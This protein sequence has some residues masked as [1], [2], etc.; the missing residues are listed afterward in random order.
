MSLS[1]FRSFNSL[2][3]LIFTFFITNACA[4]LTFTS[5]EKAR[6]DKNPT[7]TLGGDF[8]WPPYDFVGAQ[9]KHNGISADILEIISAKTGLKFDVKSGVWS[10]VLAKAKAGELDGLACAVSTEERQKYLTFTT[11]Y[12][13]MPLALIVQSSNGEIQSV[14]DLNGLTVAVNEGSYLHEWLAK[15]HPEIKLKLTKSNLES[16]E[17]ASFSQVDAYIGNVGV[18]TYLIKKH[19][20]TNLKIVAKLDNLQTKTSF[21]IQKDNPVLFNIIQ[22]ALNDISEEELNQIYKKWFF[23]STSRQI[24]L[25]K[26]EKLWIENHPVI[27]VS[28]EVDWPPFD[29]VN[30][31]GEFGGIANEYLK[32]VTELTGLKFDITTGAWSDNLQGFKNGEVELLPA[33]YKMPSRE[34]FSLFSKPYFDSINYFF[35]RSDSNIK[36]IED[37]TD[38]VLAIPKGYAHI[39]TIR[40][41]YPEV[42]LLITRSMQE[43]I[44]AVIEN[45]AQILFDNYAVLTY[46]LSH[47][48]ISNIVPFK[49]S[50]EESYQSLYFMISP[51]YPELKSIIDKVLV[52]LTLEEKNSINKLWLSSSLTTEAEKLMEQQLGING[53]QLDWLKNNREV[54][55]AGDPAWLPFE[56][57]NEDGEYVGIVSDFLKEIEKSK[58]IVFNT[59][60][61]ESWNETIQLAERGEVDVISGVEGDAVLFK[62]YLPTKSY[63]RS[64]IVIVMEQKQEFVSDLYELSDKKVVIVKDYG[65]VWKLYSNYPDQD[66]IT[67]NSVKEALEGVSIGLY[68]A[69]LLSL[70]VA[71]YQIKQNNFQNL[72]IVGK[73]NVEMFPVLFVREDLH[74]LY[75]ILNQ[76]V[77]G[78]ISK[79]AEKILDKWSKIEFA[80]QIDYDLIF[81]IVISSILILLVFIYWNLKLK[82]EIERRLII[83]ESL[84]VEKNNF[85]NLFE[86]ASDAHLI[87]IDSQIAAC[88]DSA[89]Q[90]F[91]VSAKTDM[92]F[93]RLEAWSAEQQP[94]NEAS[95]KTRLIDIYKAV[96]KG[97]TVRLDWVVSDFHGAEFWTDVIFTKIKYQG[98]NA[99]YI[100]IRDKSEQ[101]RLEQRLKQ[102]QAQLQSIIDSIPL[103]ILIATSKGHILSANKHAVNDAGNS[104]VRLKKMNIIDFFSDP[105]DMNMLLDLLQKDG[106]VK[107]Q[108]INFKAKGKLSVPMLVS[109][110]P[111]TYENKRAYLS[112]AIDMSERIELEKSLNL[113]REQ[114]ELANNA[115]SEFLANMSHEIRTPMNAILGFTELLNEQVQEPR[116]KSFVKTIQ[117]AGNTLLMLINDILDLSKIEAGKLPIQNNATNLFYLI[118]DIAEIFT[119]NIRN[120]GLELFVHVDPDLPQSIL[121]DSVR[122]RQILFNLLGNAVKFTDKGSIKLSVEATKVDQHESK[123]NL[124]ISVEDT[125]VGIAKE[126]QAK[127]FNVFEQVGEQDRNKYGGTGLGLTITK[128]LVEML[129]GTISVESQLGKGSIFKIVLNSIDIAAV[130]SVADEQKAQ[131]KTD[132]K[133]VF[134]HADILVVD[135][136]ES[137]RMLIESNFSGTNLKVTEAYDGKQAVELCEAQHFD[138]VLM[139]IQMPIM[140]GYEATELL[141]SRYPKLPVVALTASVLRNET[142]RFEKGYFDAYLRKPVMKKELFETLAEFLPH[143]VV[144]VQTATVEQSTLSDKALKH[145]YEI[146]NELDSEIESLYL[147]ANKTNSLD[148]IENFA[149]SVQKLAKQFDCEPLLSFSQRLLE[150]VESFDIAGMQAMFVEYK[151]LKHSLMQY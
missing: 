44:D 134:E 83:E 28:G 103:N 11:P 4:S 62:N 59:V 97:K 96:F 46:Q 118:D 145:I 12:T 41:K 74:E 3:V 148:D 34:V 113:A 6:I 123:L 16:L 36:Q 112:V 101:K 120:K 105:A 65:Y 111:I 25:T 26:E 109:V 21:A 133:I 13:S 99:V 55:F 140:D 53:K 1:R 75:E 19:F 18:A 42:S 31:Q 33:A 49:S 35:I 141:K 27:K 88:N 40:E 82:K 2:L 66:F 91:S 57:F 78:V 24:T 106:Y 69:A 29:F 130:S 64:P 119:I 8:F 80:R 104:V 60:Q 15:E 7:V 73:T 117:S 92:L 95:S 100:A 143:E 132:K 137:N 63:I 50:R 139:D 77:S 127:I 37:L 115:K 94:N 114:A 85:Q 107:H 79:R 110:I 61:V 108:I 47:Q 93:T 51:K 84:E 147:K 14:D 142:E 43:A 56:A 124:Q 129:G 146:Q 151:D 144:S 58:P 121:I 45:K 81:K 54:S 102:N 125:G 87:I 136:V 70:P 71:S 98:K 67:V 68:D 10:E 128:R 5:E 116:L 135:D 149:V 90:L 38:K 126:Q 39:E 122:L 48:G 52:N 72:K 17:A 150:K 30:E 131:A 20:L 138:L 76:S 86:K 9:G 23:I 22:K 32:I 89:L